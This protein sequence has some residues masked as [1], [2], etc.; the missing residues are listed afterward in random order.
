ME[1]GDGNDVVDGSIT[2]LQSELFEANVKKREI[3]SEG[4]EGKSHLADARDELVS[5]KARV[6]AGVNTKAASRGERSMAMV[7]RKRKTDC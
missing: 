5:G 4:G 6:Q 1:D 2:S 3:R 7:M